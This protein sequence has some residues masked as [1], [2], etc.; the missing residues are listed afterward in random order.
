MKRSQKVWRLV[1]LLI[2]A[3]L[4]LQ[5]GIWKETPLL[6]D[7]LAPATEAVQPQE[8]AEAASTPQTAP[9]PPAGKAL[10][11]LGS[12]G[13][14]H[15]FTTGQT[16]QSIN[17]R[18]PIGETFARAADS[19]QTSPHL[20]LTWQSFPADEG[21]TLITADGQTRFVPAPPEHR[22]LQQ[23]FVSPAED[24]LYWLYDSSPVPINLISPCEENPACPGYVFEL[25]ST[26]LAGQDTQQVTTIETGVKSFGLRMRFDHWRTGGS[27]LFLRA[28]LPIPSGHYLV[29]HGLLYE[30][31]PDSGALTTY[32]DL[33]QG[34]LLSPDGQWAANAYWGDQSVF[35]I[36]NL[37]S[38][39]SQAQ[40]LLYGPGTVIQQVTFSPAGQR[41]AWVT[42]QWDAASSGP[43]ALALQV[44]ELASGQVKTFDLPLPA[45]GNTGDL[46]LPYLS[47]WLNDE[48]MVVNTARGSRIFNTAAMNW[49]TAWDGVLH[50]GGN[51]IALGLLSG[52][53]ELPAVQALAT[54]ATN[55]GLFVLYAATNNLE[56][57]SNEAPGSMAA[58]GVWLAYNST[59]PGSEA[60]ALHL[61]NG[62]IG[63]VK[64]I[65]SLVSPDQPPAGE[66]EICTPAFEAARAP[67][68]G[69]GLAWSPD[70]SQ[71]AY[72]SA[73]HGGTTEI[74]VYAMSDGSMRKLT[75][76]P[77][78]LYDLHWSPD[79]RYLSA[80]EA[81]CFGTGAGFRMLGVWAV[82]L[83]NGKQFNPYVINPE[84][85][86][87]QEFYAW[88]DGQTMLVADWSSMCGMKNLR[89]INLI[90]GSET[91][92]VPGCV[93]SLSLSADYRTAAYSLADYMVTDSAQA[94]LYIV[95]LIDGSVL[96]HQPGMEAAEIRYEPAL[97]Q[98]LVRTWEDEALSFTT[99]GASGNYLGTGELP[100]FTPN[101]A[102][103]VI[104]DMKGV[105]LQTILD[106]GPRSLSNLQSGL[107]FWG[108]DG[109]LYF[110]AGADAY[111]ETLDLYRASPPEYTPQMIAEAVS[112]P[113]RPPIWLPR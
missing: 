85:V 53:F 86:E 95:S 63:Q 77:G 73:Q 30:V 14:F 111:A 107:A 11:F 101:G 35:E 51:F 52:N 16:V 55:D 66:S 67:F 71:L 57:V 8:P 47:A 64:D 4:V 90:Q 49:N 21:A 48:D 83:N 109:S 5:C 65:T 79:G 41:L 76:T 56:K 50:T 72:I 70:G 89:K 1:L 98:F 44:M 110:F 84:Q 9:V 106:A 33:S 91:M 99:F 18:I 3:L 75:D 38:G 34:Y 10:A 93:G 42:M 100:I 105:Q 31:N 2:A 81:D 113:Y 17:L 20:L 96:L 26:D 37:K 43:Q 29:E 23:V 97:D 108:P 24:R 69:Q 22:N 7:P 88:L 58:S 104:A 27:T 94:G 92:I 103:W 80:F 46:D 6:P 15:L 32:G 82:D 78:Q 59:P 28:Y 87:G 74:Y 60:G 40:S 68:I 61:L 36:N 45:A 62:A 112:N 25:L 12:D 19:V 54:L 13:G 102:A 39:Q